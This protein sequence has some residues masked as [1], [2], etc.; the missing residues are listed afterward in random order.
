MVGNG[1]R[2][3]SCS[4]NRIWSIASKAISGPTQVFQWVL[5]R[6]WNL[7]GAIWISSICSWITAATV[8]YLW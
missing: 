4:T 5:T 7:T 6:I 8:S 1:Q 3:K 2:L